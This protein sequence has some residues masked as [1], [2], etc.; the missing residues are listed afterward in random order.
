MLL[1]LAERRHGKDRSGGK[2]CGYAA[3]LG[4][5][6]RVAHIP[7]AADAAGSSLIFEGQEQA[8]LHLN[9]GG[10][11]SHGWGPLQT[12]GSNN[13]A[14]ETRQHPGLGLS[15][16]CNQHTVGQWVGL[17]GSLVLFRIFERHVSLYV[18]PRTANLFDLYLQCISNIDRQ[19][20][21]VMRTCRYH[22]PRLELEPLAK[23]G[24]LI[25]NFVRHKAR[26]KILTEFAVYPGLDLKIVRI[27]NFV[28][29]HDPWSTGAECVLAFGND[30]TATNE[31]PH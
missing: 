1:S 25:G 2:G 3:S 7:T 14:G 20:A 31:A 15:D 27:W 24:Q 22:V 12:P 8:R 13:E 4:Q 6:K 19:E 9:F 18:P 17:L 28:A 11:W 16:R 5:R 29:R 30:K 26:I 10:P 21:I 23:P